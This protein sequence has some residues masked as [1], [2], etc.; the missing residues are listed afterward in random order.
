MTPPP[1]LLPWHLECE[2]DDIS[3]L[4][5]CYTP[6][7]E[8]FRRYQDHWSIYFKMKRLLW[9]ISWAKSYNYTSPFE[10][11]EFSGASGKR[12]NQRNWKPKIDILL[13]A[14]RWRAS[15]ATRDWSLGAG[16]SPWLTVRKERGIL[17][18]TEQNSANNLDE[19]KR[20]FFPRTSRE[21]PICKDL[22]FSTVWQDH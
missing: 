19:Y 11:R 21:E 20:G 17:Q 14:R 16:S 2:Y 12:G 22:E 5:I 3:C 13:L 9:I 6:W 15:S 4:R 18:V 1:D 8:G 10:S 7:Q